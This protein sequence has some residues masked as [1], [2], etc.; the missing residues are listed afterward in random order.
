MRGSVG[1]DKSLPLRKLEA[2]TECTTNTKLYHY[3][4]GLCIHSCIPLLLYKNARCACEARRHIRQNA[5]VKG[6][7]INGT[8]LGIWLIHSFKSMRLLCS[9]FLGP[10]SSTLDNQADL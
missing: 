9:A 4:S 7:H 2:R 1:A 8:P 3:Q 10:P 6:K 5:K